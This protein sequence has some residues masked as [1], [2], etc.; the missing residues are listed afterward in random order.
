[1]NTNPTGPQRPYFLPSNHE[2]EHLYD[3][4]PSLYPVKVCENFH[5]QFCHFPLPI[6]GMPFKTS[7]ARGPGDFPDPAIWFHDNQA[8]RRSGFGS[9][10]F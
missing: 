6:G 4:P 9:G 1:M 7:L 10:W 8:P 5:K 3:Q 2:I